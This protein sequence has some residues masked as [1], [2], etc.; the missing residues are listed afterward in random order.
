[1]VDALHVTVKCRNLPAMDHLSLLMPMVGLFKRFDTTVAPLLH[2][3]YTTVTPLLHLCYTTVTRQ[4]HSSLLYSTLLYANSLH[5][6]QLDSTLFHPRSKLTSQYHLVDQTEV[7]RDNN[8]PNF[9]REFTLQHSL[10]DNQE[11]LLRLYD[12]QGDS[13]V[14]CDTIVMLL[15]HHCNISVAPL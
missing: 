14:N 6:S 2:H 12:V 5:S 3:G 8:N 1:V 9:E 15:E 11:Y 10:G 7:Q 13:Q 4:L